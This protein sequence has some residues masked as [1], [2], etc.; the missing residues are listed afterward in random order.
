ME[1]SLRTHTC[2]ELRSDN[3]GSTVTLCGWVNVVR[4]QGGVLFVDLRDRYGL[5][6]ITF[7]GDKDAALL[8]NAERVRP[9]WV[10]R[11]TGTVIQR[12]PDAANPNLDTGE[13]EVEVDR[14]EVLSESRTPPFPL[15]DRSDVNP[16]IR[17]RHRYLDLRRTH[18][19]KMLAGRAAIAS[20]V[21]KHLEALGFIDIETPTLIRSTP[22]GARDYLVP[23]RVRPGTCYA[24][25]QS[26]QLFKQLLMV[27]GQDRYYQIA[28]CYRDEDLRADRQPEFT[29]V[30]I[31]ASFVEQDDVFAFLEPLIVDLVK[32][33]RGHELTA[34]FQRMTHAEAMRRFGSDRPDLRNPL[35][36]I[37]VSEPAQ[38]LGFAPFE[39]AV[40]S[41]GM[42]KILVGPGAARLS[43]KEIDAFE[44]EAKSMGA[45]GLA[46]TKLG[47]E[48]PTGPLARFLGGDTGTAFLAASGAQTGDLVLCAAGDAA[49]VHRIL[50]ALRDS[51]AGKLDLV[52]TS[53]TAVLWV[54]DF[55]LLA[56]SEDEGRFAAEH[57]PFT[58]P[59]DEDLESLFEAAEHGVDEEN[60]AR[61]GQ[62]CSKGYDLVLDG[63]E[64]AGGSIRIH[65]Q[66]VQQAVFRLLGMGVEE[67]ER[68]FGWFVE[69][70]Q[71]GTPPHGGIAIGFD[72]LVMSLLGDRGIQDVIAFPKTLNAS[73][74]MCDAP[75]GVDAEQLDELGLAW[76]TPPTP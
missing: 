37:D 71:Y 64:V 55:P 49:L 38:A 26:P 25:P 51:M 5:T 60:R 22:E 16:E 10:V 32:T 65:S 8:E 24:L 9:E 74:L 4:N 20:F 62:I 76:K 39:G 41:G 53:R 18:M 30:D 12:P 59:R 56:W 72:R 19:T 6:Q 36:L 58:A 35:E 69:S 3:V 66:D 54:T 23:S 42:V 29:Q 21:R 17:L 27:G 43:R 2:G 15:D 68:R 48:K 57:H 33:W 13:I 50:S 1:T 45:P 40:A 31:E 61:V 11:A 7:R 28:R 75:A 63:H 44:T 67:V 14:L 47:D 70:L 34:P 46:W 52:D 73:D